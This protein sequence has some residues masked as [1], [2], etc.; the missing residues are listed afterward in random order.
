MNSTQICLSLAFDAKF[1]RQACECIKTIQSNCPYAHDICALVINMEKRQTEWL[2]QNGV[3]WISDYSQLPKYRDD[4]PVHAY[5]QLC[6]PYL[7]E[8]FPGYDVYM[9]IDADIRILYRD[10]FDAFL[11]S[12]L[13]EPGSIA[14]C[15]EAD[16]LYSIVCHPQSAYGY[17]TMINQRIESVYG[18]KVSEE[19][20]YFNNFN[21]G[22]WA[23]HRESRIWNYFQKALIQGLA[24]PYD[25]MREQDAMNVAVTYSHQEPVILPSTMNWLCSLTKP[26]KYNPKTRRFVR[27]DP[28]QIPISVMHL[29][30]S[31]NKMNYNG[32]TMKWYDFYKLINLTE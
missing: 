5:T 3:R 30:C 32:R 12:A 1:F 18:A 7:K 13:A 6:R 20:R 24:H 31:E 27:P 10:A 8:L 16:P 17:H 4:F 22:I 25:H 26:P 23:M 14:I 21:T 29:I 28:P 2:R 9:W 15:Q 11:G 19:L